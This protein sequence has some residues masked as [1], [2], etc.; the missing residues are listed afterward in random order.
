MYEAHVVH[1]IPGRMRVRLPFLKGASGYGQQIK[2]FLSPIEGLT[3]V[4]F[5]PV[6]GSILLHYDPELHEHFSEDLTAHVQRTMGL[7][8]VSTTTTNGSSASQE[9]PEGVVAPVIRDT[10]LA[11]D[12]ATFF[13][14]LNQSVRAETDDA[15]DLKI[16]LPVGL[17]IYAL[18]KAGSAMTT[19]LWV[20]LGIFSFTSFAILNPV[21]VTVA[22]EDD[23]RRS[24]RRK[25]PAQSK[26]S[27]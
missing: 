26:S 12:I 14:R 7:S 4:D 24:R 3:Q 2:E 17:G 19:P 27:S 5:S 6:T 1:H 25:S 15:F 18:L 10:K 22:T 20:T 21:S 9:D 11:R 8:L 13:T 16:L 23:R